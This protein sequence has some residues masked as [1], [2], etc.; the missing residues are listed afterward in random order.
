MKEYIMLL[1]W[2]L[3]T[4]VVVF[5]V[6]NIINRLRIKKKVYDS[7][8]ELVYLI[9][10]FNLK[11][12]VKKQIK[13]IKMTTVIN[14]FIIAIVANIIYLIPLHYVLQLM[15][16]FVLLI[17]LIYSVY[18]IYGRILKKKWGKK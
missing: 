4:Y 18:E 8:L 9:N 10:H 12:D 6:F 15:I 16:G 3:L 11:L 14:A 2:F 13:I 5:I 1:I 7:S 17:I